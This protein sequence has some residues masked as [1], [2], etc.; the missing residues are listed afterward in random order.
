MANRS[1]FKFFGSIGPAGAFV[2]LTE[3]VCTSLFPNA[4]NY[5]DESQME[6]EIDKQ[7]KEVRQDYIKELFHIRN[8]FLKRTD[9][10]EKEMYE[11]FITIIKKYIEKMV[12]LE[13]NKYMRERIYYQ[14]SQQ[15]VL[16][17]QANSKYKNCSKYVTD[18]CI[19]QA[20][21]I[22]KPSAEEFDRYFKNIQ[23]NEENFDDQ[24]HEIEKTIPL[25][26][27]KAH[28]DLYV[29][30]DRKLQADKQRVAQIAGSPGNTAEDLALIEKI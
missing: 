6:S 28:F 29:D 23:V 22:C 19:K 26:T 12:R 14:Y 25:L 30:L 3:K 21:T 24:K 18:N 13:K 17:E 1:V 16:Y 27:A 11:K 7:L 15:S 2:S 10:T 8:K 4:Y 9:A 5:G 20:K